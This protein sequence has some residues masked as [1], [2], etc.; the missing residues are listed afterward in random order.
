MYF[1][2]ATQKFMKAN[3]LG[4]ELTVDKNGEPILVLE[5]GEIV[6][7]QGR[8]MHKLNGYA[9]DISITKNDDIWICS[10]EIVP[11]GFIVYK[12]VVGDQI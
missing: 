8:D 3:G 2:F 10:S 6:H 12:G 7:R 4:S 1:D 9:K 5:N 11:G